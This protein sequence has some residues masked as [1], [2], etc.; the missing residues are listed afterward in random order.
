MQ[1]EKSSAALSVKNGNILLIKELITPDS[2][3]D[4]TFDELSEAL[5]EYCNPMPSIIVEQFNFYMCRQQ[6]NQTISD[7][8]THLKKQYK[9][10]KFGSTIQDMLM[11]LLVVGVVNNH[12]H[13][14]LLADKNLNF[15]LA[16]QIALV[17][18]SADKNVHNIAACFNTTVNT[19]SQ[20]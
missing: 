3:Q 8:I 10:C 18:E 2:L 19:Q 14:C 4:K 1:T 7:F 17:T 9:F 11:D 16:K 13:R 6:S 15:D 12:I 5:E 20:I